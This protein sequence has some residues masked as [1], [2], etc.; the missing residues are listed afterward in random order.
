MALSFDAVDDSKQWYRPK[1]P[2]NTDPDD[3]NPFAVLISVMSAQELRKLGRANGQI[4]KGGETNFAARLQSMEQQIVKDHV[5]GVK[6]FNV[7]DKEPSN[8]A[9]LLEALAKIPARAYELILSDIIEA[10]QDASVLRAGLLDKPGPSSE[11]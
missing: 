8:G 11:S 10:I 1:V 7:G 5:H 2:G 4:T 9:E 6:G 3:P